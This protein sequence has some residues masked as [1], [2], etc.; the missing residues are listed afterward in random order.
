MEILATSEMKMRELALKVESLDS[1]LRKTWLELD[2][3]RE[4]VSSY[5]A[6]SMCDAIVILFISHHH[7]QAIC[8]NNIKSMMYKLW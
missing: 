8:M 5:L 6:A 2:S 7:M 4:C 3:L 1:V